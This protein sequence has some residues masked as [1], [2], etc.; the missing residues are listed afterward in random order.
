MFTITTTRIS[1]FN[2][3]H[4][5]D[6]TSPAAIQIVQ[7]SLPGATSST[8]Q[9]TS[10]NELM[11]DGLL[12]GV[13]KKRRTAEKRLHRRFGVENYPD[14]AKILRTRNDLVVCERCGDH[15]EYY[16]ICPTCYSKVKEETKRMQ[17]QLRQQTNP[18]QPKEKDILFRYENE[19]N[20]ESFTSQ[21]QQQQ[22]NE[23]FQ[24][25]DIDH[26]R[27]QWF[28]RNLMIKSTGSTNYNPKDVIMDP[29]DL[30]SNN[31][32]DEN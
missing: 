25:I 4:F 16:A 32:K 29:K 26:P 10:I 2:L 1:R 5:F 21:Q 7:L 31:K 22:K 15:H 17:D 14:S 18:L 13:P 30:I 20:D 28:S 3:D 23:F 11:Q 19:K 12:W 24:I 8:S 6:H 27:P 9:S